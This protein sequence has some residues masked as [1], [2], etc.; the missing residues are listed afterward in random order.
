MKSRFIASI[1]VMTFL[2]GCSVGG[3]QFAC[4]GMPDGVSCMSAREVYQATNNADKLSRTGKKPD[5]EV[6]APAENIRTAAMPVPAIDNPVPIRTQAKVLR[7]WFAPWQTESGDLNVPG[8]AYTEIEPRRWNM[9][10]NL[11][12]KQRSATPFALQVN[13]GQPAKPKADGSPGRQMQVGNQVSPFGQPGNQ[14][15]PR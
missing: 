11:V 5:G 3:S 7:I 14:Q 8:Y 6:A 12:V 10:E 1:A 13:S 15:A 9:G 4:N 2:G